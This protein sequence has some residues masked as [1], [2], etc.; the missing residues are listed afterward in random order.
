MMRCKH[1][2]LPICA[3]GLSVLFGC[4]IATQQALL[5]AY[6]EAEPP[7]ELFVEVAESSYLGSPGH[8]P[9]LYYDF[10]WSGAQ[11][12]YRGTQKV[13]VFD[14]SYTYLGYY[15]LGSTLDLDQSKVS[16]KT[17]T[18][19]LEDGEPERLFFHNGPPD[20]SASGELWFHPFQS[21]D[22]DYYRP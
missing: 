15:Y 22:R 20:Q 7:N 8:H 9:L 11:H 10:T 6:H 5:D 1:A 4:E 12:S 19:A 3:I 18:L 13:L 16:E 14:R 21:L 2:G 17:I